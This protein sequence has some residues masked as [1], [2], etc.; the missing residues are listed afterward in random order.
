[1]SQKVSQYFDY[2][3]AGKNYKLR[4]K[5]P[6]VGQQIAIGQAY[7]ALKAGFDKLDDMSDSLAYAVATLNIVIVDKP[8]DLKLDEIEVND[9]KVLNKMLTDY[10]GFAFFRNESQEPEIKA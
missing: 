5:I 3:I 9:W 6:N 1:M 7:A 4:Y 8:A 10:Q 2:T